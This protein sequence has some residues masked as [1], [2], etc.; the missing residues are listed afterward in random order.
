MRKPSVKAMTAR[1]RPFQAPSCTDGLAGTAGAL[2]FDVGVGKTRAAIAA[3]QKRRTEGAGDCPVIV[4]PN[5]VI[6]TTG[7]RDAH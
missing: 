2:S 4:V 7:E 1:R 6:S 3:M 5:T